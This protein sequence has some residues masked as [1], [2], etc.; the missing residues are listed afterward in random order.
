MIG[1]EFAEID[2]IISHAL[3]AMAILSDGQVTVNEIAN[4]S[5]KGQGTP[6][7]APRN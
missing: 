4:F 1:D 5:V 3:E 2:K 7:P 6:L